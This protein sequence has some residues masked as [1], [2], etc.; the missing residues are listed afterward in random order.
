[1]V[2]A[3]SFA[4]L[5]S[6]PLSLSVLTTLSDPAFI[7]ELAEM[8]LDYCQPRDLCKLEYLENASHWV[9]HDEIEKVIQI[10]LSFLTS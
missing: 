4:Q 3:S 1:L 8:S 7:P 2:Q 5:C 10:I 6:P 9:Q